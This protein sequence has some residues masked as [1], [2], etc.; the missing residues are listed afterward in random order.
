MAAP[1]P[2]GATPMFPPGMGRGAQPTSEQIE[3]IKASIAQ[4]AQK[5]GMTVPQ[6]LEHVKQQ[7]A[8]MMAARQ[9]QLQQQVGQQGQP[10]QAGQQGLAPGAAG[11]PQGEARLPGAMPI[12]PG[13]PNPQALAVA[14]FLQSQ[15]L[16]PRTSI[17]N[18]ERRQMFRGEDA[19]PIVPPCITC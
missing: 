15:D 3:A 10:Q 9:Q 4:Q 11:P 8:R 5:A 1:P 14:K 12:K 18:G 16:K 2:S 7:Q 6:F 19:I 17:L 13:P